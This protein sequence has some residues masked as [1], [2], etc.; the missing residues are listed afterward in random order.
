[1]D[2]VKHRAEQ[3]DGRVLAAVPPLPKTP[4]DLLSETR[5]CLRL[6]SDLE[7]L[8]NK[9]HEFFSFIKGYKGEEASPQ[10]LKGLSGNLRE[11]YVIDGGEEKDPEKRFVRASDGATFYFGVTL[12][13]P[14]KGEPL[15]L[16]AYRFQIDLPEGSMPKFLR[17]DLNSASHQDPVVE[18]RCHLHPGNDD[19]RTPAPLLHP[20]EVLQILIF[21]SGS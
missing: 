6:A 8:R 4:K 19:L 15:Q 21:A 17:F 7:R 3:R 5:N 18:P 20:V 1:M 9:P 2:D 11:Y 14:D 16:V 13:C 12:R 10:L